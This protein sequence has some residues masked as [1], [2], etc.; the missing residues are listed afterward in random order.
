MN[1]PDILIICGPTASGKSKFALE[2]AMANDGEIINADATQI[3]KEIPILSCSPSEED[4]KHIPHHLYN[5]KSLGD[6]YSVA[7][8]LDEISKAIKEVISK[9]KLPII[10]G[11][12]G[13]YVKAMVEGLSQIPDIPSDIRK[14]SKEMLE[15]LGNQA[16]YNELKK[17]DPIAAAK[18]DPGNSQRLIRAYEVFSH[19]GKSIYDFHKEKSE[20]LLANF[21]VKVIIATANREKLY[22]RCNERFE[23]IFEI[24]ALEEVKKIHKNTSA[25]AIGFEEISSYLNGKITKEKAIE[26]ASQKTRNYA[27]RQV[28]FFAHQIDGE[29]IDM[30]KM[31]ES[32][33]KLY[34]AK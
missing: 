22:Q 5:H 2:V 28:T 15:N 32:A 29:E 23:H 7:I 33:A 26:I 11:G 19:T 12:T 27:K 17:L 4:K 16:F 20:P 3:Y 6:E 25:K 10:V 14:K 9:G 13:L 18:L 34:F 31:N 24:G 30:D 21:N 8:F 1:K